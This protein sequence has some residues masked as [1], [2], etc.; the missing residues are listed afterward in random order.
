MITRRAEVK[1]QTRQ[2]QMYSE[3]SVDSTTREE[4]CR[5]WRIPPAAVKARQNGVKTFRTLDN[6]F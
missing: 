4:V 2:I 1:R 3:A 6:I 5:R